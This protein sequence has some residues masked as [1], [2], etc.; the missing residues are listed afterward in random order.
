MRPS[1]I[2]ASSVAIFAGSF[3]VDVLIGVATAPGPTPTTVM[4]CGP[5]S[6]PAVRVSM[7]MPPFDRQYGVLPGIGQSSCT[8]VMLMIRPP[9]PWAIICLAASW[10]PKKA[11][12]RLIA[13]TFSYCASVVSSDRRAGLDAG[14]VDHDVEAAEGLDGRV[15]EALQVVDLADVGVDADGLVAERDDLLLEVLG[16]L[17]VGDVVDDDVGAR[18]GQRQHDG[19]ADAAVAA[20]D[21]GDLAVE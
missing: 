7:R 20:G 19:L 3:I 15:D 12:L 1:G 10:V 17:L 21:D 9:S 4:P 8:D 6:T 14:V 16:G 5:S 11:L 18:R 2:A 13:M